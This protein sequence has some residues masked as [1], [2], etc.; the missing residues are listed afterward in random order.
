MKRIAYFKKF[1]YFRLAFLPSMSDFNK[2][3]LAQE[4]NFYF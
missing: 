1:V 2:A 4:T 3:L